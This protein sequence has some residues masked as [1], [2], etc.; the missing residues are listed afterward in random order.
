MTINS[1]ARPRLADQVLQQAKENYTLGLSPAGEPV[2]AGVDGRQYKL[3]SIGSLSGKRAAEPFLEQLAGL[4][5]GSGLGAVARAPLEQALTVLR[6]LAAKGPTLTPTRPEAQGPGKVCDFSDVDVADQVRAEHGADLRYCVQT[7]NWLVFAQGRWQPDGLAALGR[8]EETVLTLVGQNPT[9][10]KAAMMKAQQRLESVLRNLR[11]KD[12]IS[13]SEEDLD[14]QPML[15]NA[16]NGTIDLRTAELRPHD[17]SEL[18]TKT[19]AAE[20]HPDAMCPI[21]VSFLHVACGGDLEL[22]A[23]LHRALGYSL[24]GRI[25]AQ[26][27]FFVCGIGQNGKTTMLEMVRRLLDGYA[28]SI[29]ARVLLASGESDHPA[30][31]ADLRG[32]RFVVASEPNQG[33]TWNE[34][35]VK[36]LTGSDELRARWMG[37]NFFRFNPTHKL[38]FAANNEPTLTS[39]EKAMRRRLRLIPFTAVIPDGQRDDD[40]PAKLWTER[41]GILAWLVQGC[42]AWLTEGLGTAG[43]IEAATDSY[44][45][46]QDRVGRFLHEAFIIG[47]VDDPNFWTESTSVFA[48]WQRWCLREGVQPKDPSWLN[49]HLADKGLLCAAKTVTRRRHILGLRALG[50]P[51]ALPGRTD[52]L[53]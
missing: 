13:V 32:A 23:Y 20:Y 43:L 36:S 33:Q 7:R 12:G 9:D 27:F 14:T 46:E 39:V 45:A 19:V 52:A 53:R 41:E 35:L 50:L 42:Q 31:K 16:L 49:R 47:S 24:T 28:V 11:H 26:C 44:F 5:Y 22:I 15:L 25:S 51:A 38:W 10:P 37:Q 8:V 21:W 2:A 34:G 1:P 48:S 6:T 30:A 40:L 17:R 4:A 29:D 18:H 3:G